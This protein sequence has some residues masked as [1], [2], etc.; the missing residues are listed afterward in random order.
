VSDETMADAG[1][2]LTIRLFGSSYIELP[3]RRSGQ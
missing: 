1:D 3:V 2:P